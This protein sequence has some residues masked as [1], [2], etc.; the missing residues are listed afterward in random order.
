MKKGLVVVFLLFLLFN[1][2]LPV[3]AVVPLN[4]NPPPNIPY[5]MGDWM[6]GDWGNPDY[7]FEYIDK[8]GKRQGVHGH[9]EWG[10]VGGWCDFG[11]DLCSGGDPIE[12]IKRAKNLTIE[13]NGKEIPKPVGVGIKFTLENIQDWANKILNE[14]LEPKKELDNLAFLVA[15]SGSKYGEV[16]SGDRLWAR[17]VMDSLSSAFPNIP[18]FFQGD[19]HT[20]GELGGQAIAMPNKN[21]GIKTNSWAYDSKDAICT[22]QKIRV[23]GELIESACEMS[24]AD[25]YGDQIMI[26]FE[27][28]HG[29]LEDEYW[30]W[31]TM[32]ALSHHPDFFDIQGPHGQILSSMTRIETNWKFPLLKF[33]RDHTAKTIENAPDVWVVLRA[34]DKSK[35]CDEKGEDCQQPRCVPCSYGEAPDPNCTEPGLECRAPRFCYRQGCNHPDPANCEEVCFGPEKGNFS[36]WLYQMDNFPKGKTVV[37]P[38]QSELLPPTARK[39]L[40]GQYRVRRTDQ[41][42]GNPYMY[43]DIDDGYPPAGGIPLSSGGQTTWEVTVTFINQG[44]DELSLEYRD[45]TGNLVR[46]TIKKGSHLGEVN[47]W[48]DY[49][50]SLK[51][52]YFN[53]N[54][55]GVDFR[56]NS[57]NDGD[58]IVHRVM[59]K[60]Y[61]KRAGNLDNDPEGLIDEMDLTILLN[62]WGTSFD[63]EDLVV[64]LSNW[65]VE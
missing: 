18:I 57:Q 1:S 45:Y 38:N 52:A 4:V 49:T 26:G 6:N 10:P 40:Y 31:A 15:V 29:S 19:V 8:E 5:V 48:V 30:Y 43:F 41:A 22:T 3:W 7:Y 33:L 21:I 60:G 58:E 62:Q 32:Q 25:L 27:P 2:S 65:R 42:S 14:K 44:N 61:G 53:N 39:H 54:L 28:K 59:V 9:P 24:F 50:F 56:I 35:L 13:L 11:K 46:R 23:G 64:L 17:E 16:T 20:L 37:L 34:T 47:Q 63:Q 36:Y 51:D 55:E 12:Y